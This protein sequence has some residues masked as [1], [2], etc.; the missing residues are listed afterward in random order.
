MKA[1]RLSDEFDF[2]AYLGDTVGE[3]YPLFVVDASGGLRAST[4]QETETKPQ[5]GEKVIG[6]T[7]EKSAD[8]SP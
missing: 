4:V 5:P 8:P 6:L 3:V 2:D 1:T 7:R